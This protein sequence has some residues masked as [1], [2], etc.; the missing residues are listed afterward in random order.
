MADVVAAGPVAKVTVLEQRPGLL[1]A[2]LPHTDYRLHLA[3]AGAVDAPVGRMVKGT[4]R[5]Q[6]R[7]IDVV[8]TG[9]AFVEPLFGQPRRLQ[10]RVASVDNSGNTLTVACPLPVVVTPKAPQQA[11]D[12]SDGQLVAFDVESG[13]SFDPA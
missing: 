13:T 1:V 4:I 11:R 8:S 3:L 9:G 2:G 10:G 7:R 6:A 5:A 12:F